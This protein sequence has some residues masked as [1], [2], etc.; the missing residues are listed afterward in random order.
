MGLPYLPKPQQPKMAFAP[1]GEAVDMNSLPVG[2]SFA[3]PSKPAF[4]PGQTR[5]IKS[6]RTIYTQEFQPDGSWKQIGKSSIDKPD[7]P[8]K[9]QKPIWDPTRGGFVTPPSGGQGPSFTPVP[10]ADKPMK[11]VKPGEAYLKQQAGVNNVVSALDDYINEL[12]TFGGTDIVNPDARAKM[13]TVY[14]NALLQAK[15]AFNLGVLNGPD[16]SILQQTL[17]DPASMRG[18]ITSNDAMKAQAEKLQEL[19][20][21]VAKGAQAAHGQGGNGA[22]GGWGGSSGATVSNW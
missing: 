2:K 1:N 17:T 14:N 13:G 12:K 15:E 3:A 11:A 5:E 9:P 7:G 16:Y 10:G 20:R 6:G 22:S 8:E 4:Q 19:M 18:A 21:K